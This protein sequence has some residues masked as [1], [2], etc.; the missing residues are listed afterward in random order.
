MVLLALIFN[1]LSSDRQAA[2]TLTSF[3]SSHEGRIIHR[4]VL[5]CSFCCA[6][7]LVNVSYQT[8]KDKIN[9]YNIDIINLTFISV[10]LRHETF[11]AVSLVAV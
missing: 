4:L 9:K 3:A 8:Q 5:T 11:K 1:F 2:I 6:V 7:F 10:C